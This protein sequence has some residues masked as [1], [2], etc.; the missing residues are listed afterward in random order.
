MNKMFVV[1]C[2]LALL[3]SCDNK[4]KKLIGHWGQTYETGS[5]RVSKVVIINK[6]SKDKDH[7]FVEMHISDGT[8]VS[9]SAGNWV[10]KGDSL[11]LDYEGSIVGSKA[12]YGERT[13]WKIR[14][15]GE[16][17]VLEDKGDT[18]SFTRLTEDDLLRIMK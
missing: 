9:F 6:V 13:A 18:Q 15:L 2:L 14:S 8:P 16:T 10:V 5:Y 4:E 11:I 12:Y 7:T 1:I 17:L 3:T